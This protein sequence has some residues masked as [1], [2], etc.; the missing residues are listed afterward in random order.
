MKKYIVAGIIVVFFAIL[1]WGLWTNNG[2]LQHGLYYS[3]D[4][5][6][7][8]QINLDGTFRFCIDNSISY[9]P[10]GNYMVK[11]DL[12]ILKESIK[13]HEYRFKI[14]KRKLIFKSSS[15]EIGINEGETYKLKKK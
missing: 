13:L 3:E 10:C 8:I 11:D 9:V 2:A 7:Y 14:K 15:Y 1:I 5:K 4:E 6:S 12:L